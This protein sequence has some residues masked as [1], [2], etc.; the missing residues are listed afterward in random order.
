VYG[1]RQRA[2]SPYAAVVPLFLGALR[3]QRAPRI[4]GDGLQ[5]RD[6]T[7]VSDAVRANL[8]AADAPG[9]RCAGRIYNV[10]GGERH[11]V[12]DL[13]AILGELMGVVPHAEHTEPRPG[14]VRASQADLTAAKMD[15]GY[16]PQVPLRHGLRQLVT[17]VV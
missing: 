8:L 14:D 9:E 1:P 3:H 17:P 12:L 11:T 15:L 6:F 13:L 16:E 5:S 7:F 4:H 2:D 10:S